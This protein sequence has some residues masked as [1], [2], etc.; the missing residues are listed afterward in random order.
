MINQ[1]SEE[2]L[3]KTHYYPL[4]EGVYQYLDRY[5]SSFIERYAESIALFLSIAIILSGIVS[6]Y[7]KWNK[8]R[9]KRQN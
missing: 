7:T 4:H 6:S 3:Q 8:Q 9:K 1:I 2:N 5:Q